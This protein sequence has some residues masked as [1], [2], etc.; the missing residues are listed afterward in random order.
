MD[1][2]MSDMK[3][4]GER[5]SSQKVIQS[6][7]KLK[8]EEMNKNIQEI[9][10]SIDSNSFRKPSIPT[11]RKKQVSAKASVFDNLIKLSRFFFVQL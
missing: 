10:E 6:I 1:K 7:T 4:I 5:S 9:Q 3:M 8:I 2:Y 11:F